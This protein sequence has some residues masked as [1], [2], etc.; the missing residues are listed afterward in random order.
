MIAF[1]LALALSL[2]PDSAH[3][4]M[5]T[6]RDSNYNVAIV[7]AGGGYTGPGDIVSGASLWVGLRAYTAAI[8]AA[9]TQKLINIRNT[10]TSETCDVIVATNG[11]FGK[12]AN[13]S[14]SSSGDTVAVF[15][16]ESSGS[17]AVTEAYD[18]SGNGLDV[19]QSTAADQPSLLLSGCGF[20]FGGGGPCVSFPGVA[21]NG[22]ISSGTVT[23]VTALSVFATANW[24][25]AGDVT[26]QH[27]AFDMELN[28]GSSIAGNIGYDVGNAYVYLAASTSTWLAVVGVGSTTTNQALVGANGTNANGTTAA[29]SNNSTVQWGMRSNGA[30]PMNGMSTEAGHWNSL[31]F[32]STQITNL[33]SNTRTYWGF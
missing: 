29:L 18:Q 28:Y 12:V 6:S 26:G 20:T 17:C 1:L 32:N 33:T 16:A 23:Y 11:G 10:A 22:L 2:A 3:A 9:A 14:A 24:A 31:Q 30:A 8:A 5:G 27:T 15:C 19:S 13:C 21:S 4:G 25:A 7:A